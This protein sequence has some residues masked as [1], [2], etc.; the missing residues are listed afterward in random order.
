M[1]MRWKLEG[2][3][4]DM[5]EELHGLRDKLG[6]T[7]VAYALVEELAYS[8]PGKPAELVITRRKFP[9]AFEQLSGSVN[10]VNAYFIQSYAHS[11]VH[12]WLPPENKIGKISLRIKVHFAGQ[13]CK[14]FTVR[15]T[16]VT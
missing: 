9:W 8:S 14:R 6:R 4:H 12:S 1:E 3:I 5:E 16:P 10:I 2:L 15:L 13:T 11:V 7:K